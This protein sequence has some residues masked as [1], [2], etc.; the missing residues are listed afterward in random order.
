MAGVKSTIAVVLSK[1]R[2]TS[3]NV[4]LINR[5]LLTKKHHP[6]DDIL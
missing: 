1:K 3:L 2:T 4:S 5:P 6:Y